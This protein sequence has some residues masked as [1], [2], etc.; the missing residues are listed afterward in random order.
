ME[1]PGGAFGKS[2]IMN[3]L[4]ATPPL[5]EGMLSPKEQ[6]QPN[7]V[8]LTVK[9]VALLASAGR[10]TVSNEHRRLS[11]LSPLCFDA[12]GNLDLLPGCYLLTY[13]E[14]VN[15]PRDVMALG[16]PRSSLGRCG[17]SLHTS[18]WD[19]G[20]SGRSQS[21]LVVY[22]PMGFSLER[23]ARVVQ[24]VFFTV[25]GSAGGGY[26]GIYQRENA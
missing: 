5:I 11:M 10:I 19:A 21:L 23:S 1:L 13:N 18:V 6:I 12:L 24:L 15:L 3:L 7:G 8:D 4:N 26:S 2:E 25:V 22:N 16:L 20:Y 17:V 14:V 9:E